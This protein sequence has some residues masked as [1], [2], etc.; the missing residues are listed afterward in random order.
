M[1][2]QMAYILLAV[3]SVN[4]EKLSCSTLSSKYPPPTKQHQQQQQQQQHQQ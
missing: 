3:V 2:L 4:C 1:A